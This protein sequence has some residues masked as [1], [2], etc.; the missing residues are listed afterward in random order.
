MSSPITVQ[1]LPL[2][3]MKIP[4]SEGAVLAHHGRINIFWNGIFADETRTQQKRN[5]QGLAPHIELALEALAKE[6]TRLSLGA[7]A[8]A[9][10]AVAQRVC[11]A[12]FLMCPDADLA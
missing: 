11:H 10:L 1:G 9:V 12:C 5:L 2:P 4:Q 6:L 3:M 7:D 8:Q